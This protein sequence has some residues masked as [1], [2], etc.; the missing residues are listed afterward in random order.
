MLGDAQQRKLD[1]DAGN[2]QH[3]DRRGAEAKSVDWCFI[4]ALQSA[5]NSSM[6]GMATLGTKEDPHWMMLTGDRV[7]ADYGYITTLSVPC[8]RPCTQYLQEGRGSKSP[9]NTPPATK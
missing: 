6:G 4:H 3:E 9:R 8:M 7:G 5:E 2:V 1:G